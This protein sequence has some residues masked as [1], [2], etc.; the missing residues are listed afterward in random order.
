MP[1]F[2][3]EQPFELPPLLAHSV[4]MAQWE[5]KT[6]LKACVQA[7]ALLGELKQAIVLL[8]NADVLLSS[9]VLLDQRPAQK[10]KTSSPPQTIYSAMPSAMGSGPMRR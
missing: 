10:L 5:S 1:N 8:P 3:P 9:F 7:H 2:A 6:V 4:P